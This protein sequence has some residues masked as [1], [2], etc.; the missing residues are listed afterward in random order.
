[1]YSRA[2]AS[3]ALAHP[4]L[5]EAWA[6]AIESNQKATGRRKLHASVST[7]D[8]ALKGD[9]SVTVRWDQNEEH[10]EVRH[11]ASLDLEFALPMREPMHHNRTQNSISRLPMTKVPQVV[12][13]ESRAEQAFALAV[14]LDGQYSGISTQPCTFTFADGTRHTPDLCIRTSSN[15]LVLVDVRP[16]ERRDSGSMVKFRATQEI[17]EKV[18]IAYVLHDGFQTRANANLKFLWRFCGRP[19]LWGEVST[20]LQAMAKDDE[21]VTW[22]QLLD[23]AI[24][25]MGLSSLFVK[26]V[27][28][29]AIWTGLLTVNLQNRFSE[30]T[31]LLWTPGR[32]K[33]VI[34]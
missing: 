21:K 12:I 7:V 24:D 2:V 10:Y 29:H 15:Q 16:Y 8:E 27:I 4:R 32:Y 3:E 30:R 23:V 9:V 22:G 33:A 19:R 18:G 5:A 1:M 6:L 34:R 13:T 28:G 20:F 25:Q 11:L 14:D 17:C 31:P 26:P